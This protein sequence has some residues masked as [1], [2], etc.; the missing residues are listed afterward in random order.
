M[1]WIGVYHDEMDVIQ[2]TWK[3]FFI[4]SGRIN[5]WKGVNQLK[6]LFFPNIFFLNIYL[7]L[8]NHWYFVIK[9]PLFFTIHNKNGFFY[10]SDLTPS[11]ISRPGTHCLQW[12]RA[13]ARANLWWR[14]EPFPGETLCWKT[15][16]AKRSW[17]C[18]GII[19]SNRCCQFS[20]IC[21]ILEEIHLKQ[22]AGRRPQTTCLLCALRRML[23]TG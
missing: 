22:S 6:E 1:P 16:F 19:P 2:W 18:L 17:W 14:H 15:G 7:K 11:P 20:M 5:T 9:N 8:T 4:S 3:F 21:Q 10:K 23:I 13:N 12:Q